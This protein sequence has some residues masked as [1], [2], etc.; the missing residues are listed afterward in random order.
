[1]AV[2][3]HPNLTY[4]AD[5]VKKIYTGEYDFGAASDGDGDRNMVLGRKFFVNPSDSVAIIAANAKVAPY[6]ANGVRALAR[7]MPTSGALDRVA[8]DLGTQFYEVPTGWKFFGNIMDDFQAKGNPHSVICGEESFGT[9]SDHIREKDGLW[10]VMFWLQILA[11]KNKDVPV[12]SP[13]MSVEDIVKEHWKKYGRNYYSRYDYEEV[14]AKPADEMMKQLEKQLPN[15]VGQSYMDG[16]FKVVTA[17]Q[18]SYKDPFD[19]S[20]TSNQ[21][22]RIIGEDGSRIIFRLSGTGSSGATIRMYLEKYESDPNKLYDETLDVLKSLVELGLSLSQ[23]EK[24]TG[25]NKPT[26]IT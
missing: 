19:S 5:L 2:Y 9:G 22:I 16:K 18:F 26:V 15:L 4:A 3:I 6:F 11:H 7:S 13:L 1:L 8:K 23:L 25:R 12:G 24:F 20:V 21:G 17:D 10:A 14:D